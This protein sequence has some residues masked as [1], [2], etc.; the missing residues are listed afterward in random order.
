V[1]WRLED[2]FLIGFTRLLH[3]DFLEDSVTGD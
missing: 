2:G 1:A 3:G